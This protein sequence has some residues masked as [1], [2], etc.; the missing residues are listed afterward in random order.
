[1]GKT[2]ILYGIH[3]NLPALE[4]VAEDARRCGADRFVCLGATVARGPYPVECCRW[5]LAQCME[6]GVTS[7]G[8]RPAIDSVWHGGHDDLAEIG[9]DGSHPPTAREGNL[10]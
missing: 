2:A 9:S 8:S 7:G 1:M 4:A 3:A 10:G 5:V 6:T